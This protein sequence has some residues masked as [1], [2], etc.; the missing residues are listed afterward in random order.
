MLEYL[1]WFKF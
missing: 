1:P